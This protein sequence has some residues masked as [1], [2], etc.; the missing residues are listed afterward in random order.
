ME[1]IV[2]GVGGNALLS[3][4]KSQS[5]IAEFKNAVR[6]VRG[7]ANIVDTG[8][9]R[10]VMTHGN[11]P[12]VGDELI[13]NEHSKDIVPELPLYIL[14][15]ETEAS[16]GSVLETTL[17]SEFDRFN[18][19]KEISVLLT[20]TIV[21]RKDKA[22]SRPSKPIGPLY[23]KTELLN[24]LRAGKF[25]Y[26]KVGSK[27][28]R[29]VPSPEPIRVLEAETI[30][31]LVNNAVVIAA[32][33]G[34]VPVFKNGDEYV[35]VNAVIDKDMTTQVLANSIKAD[36]MVILTDVDYV[37]GDF[38]SMKRPIKT[39]R[40]KDLRASLGKFEEGTMRPKLEACMRFVEKG[41]RTAQIG[42][43]Y[44]LGDILKGKSGTLILP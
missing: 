20:H 44:K 42:N 9:Y 7:I 43:L 40:A 32:G 22:F 23:S 13:K 21:D 37:Y 28:R 5:V 8:K 38:K 4:G 17:K 27:Y 11:G 26:I 34:G 19:D 12:Q 2:I 6:A 30:K 10:M 35:G 33:G 24:E 3:P 25:E 14:T 15:A 41:G 29:I 39:I 16:V 31:K 18:I 1:T 36:R